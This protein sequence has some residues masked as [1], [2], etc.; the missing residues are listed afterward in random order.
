MLLASQAPS[1]GSFPWL[2]LPSLTYCG[3]DCFALLMDDLVDL[4]GISAAFHTPYLCPSAFG[5]ENLT[6]QTEQF[7][8]CCSKMV[9]SNMNNPPSLNPPV[10]MNTDS[11]QIPVLEPGYKESNQDL[12]VKGEGWGKRECEGERGFTIIRLEKLFLRNL[13]SFQEF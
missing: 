12:V 2:H 13:D 9:S 11:F 4:P 6:A 5:R 3:S 1:A 8:F 7:Q 10:N